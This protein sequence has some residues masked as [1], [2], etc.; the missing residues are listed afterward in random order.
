MRFPSP[1]AG[2]QLE[3]LCKPYVPRQMKNNSSWATGV[4]RVWAAA[5]NASPD[6][7]ATDTVPGDI[8]EVRYPLHV[9]DRTLA[10]FVFEARRADGKPYHTLG[11]R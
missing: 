2:Q 6:V 10:A 7:Q 5:R 3:Q 11:A 8:L 1:L 9:I 4:F